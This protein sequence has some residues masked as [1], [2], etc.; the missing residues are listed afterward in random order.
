M[1]KYI[2]LS[3]LIMSLVTSCVSPKVYK[4]L[5]SKYNTLKNQNRELSAENEA[6]LNAKN[7]AA[8]TISS[9]NVRKNI[10]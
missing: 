3:I 4:D 7:K 2:I 9:N 1:K 10:E 8:K 6:L 5:E